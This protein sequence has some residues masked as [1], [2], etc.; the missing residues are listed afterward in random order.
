MHLRRKHLIGKLTRLRT[1]CWWQPRRPPLHSLALIVVLCVAFAEPLIC[2][3]H[4]QLYVPWQLRNQH[5]HTPTQTAN[6][7][8]APGGWVAPAHNRI[9]TAAL[10][11]RA[12]QWC[13]YSTRQ[14]LE[15]GAIVPPAPIHE[16]VLTPVLAI[17][18][19]ARLLFL[20]W[21]ELQIR[22]IGGIA[23]PTPPPRALR[24][25]HCSTFGSPSKPADKRILEGSVLHR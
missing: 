22:T 23:P 1:L 19:L 10:P 24:R 12:A 9:I 17:G 8:Q 5:H 3:L 6:V 20:P 18:A 25:S 16:L 7:H 4:C 21:R 14:P 15:P 11:T 2:I 13:A